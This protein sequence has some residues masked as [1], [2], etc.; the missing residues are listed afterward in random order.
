MEFSFDI[1]DFRTIPS[2]ERL[3]GLQGNAL[4]RELRTF[5]AENIHYGFCRNLLGL[6]TIG[7]ISSLFGIVA[8]GFATIYADPKLH[9]LAAVYTC[10]NIGL[11]LLSFF[12]INSE[13]VKQPAT[14]RRGQHRR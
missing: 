14:R 7:I 1:T 5:L 9:V 4:V 10:V 12:L 8:S 3:D 6:R 13:L 2:V 11:L